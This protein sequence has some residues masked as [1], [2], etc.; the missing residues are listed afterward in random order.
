MIGNFVPVSD[1]ARYMVIVLRDVNLWHARPF[2]FSAWTDVI[3]LIDISI[4]I[5]KI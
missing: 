3:S 2:D 4:P 1:R 5:P